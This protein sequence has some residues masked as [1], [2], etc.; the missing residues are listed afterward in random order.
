MLLVYRCIKKCTLQ[1]AG[2]K[3]IVYA[4]KHR[5]TQILKNTCALFAARRRKDTL[6]QDLL[7]ACGVILYKKLRDVPYMFPVSSELI[8]LLFVNPLFQW[9]PRQESD[10]RHMD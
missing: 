6:G 10:L 8:V 5:T 7:S 1:R 9:C 4:S 3:N 2:K